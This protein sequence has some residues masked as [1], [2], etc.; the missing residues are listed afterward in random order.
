PD[1][2][3]SGAFTADQNVQLGLAHITLGYIDFQR[4]A[5]TRKVA[6][7]IQELTTAV[8]LLNGNP[9]LQG[10]ALFFLGNAYEFEYPPN[11]R[12]AID[13]LTKAASLP[14]GFQG[15]SRDLL[16]KVRQAAH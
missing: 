13:A 5:K 15:Q 3:A 8:G 10:K 4:A 14:S 6:P 9:E 2:V 7:A 12:S 16:A 11:H 1:G